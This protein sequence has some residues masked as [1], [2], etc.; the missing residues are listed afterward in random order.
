MEFTA[1]HAK[2][3]KIFYRSLRSVRPLRFSNCTGRGCALVGQVYDLTRVRLNWPGILAG[4]G[5]GLTYGLY[6]LFS[7]AAQRRYTSW[8]TLAYALGFGALFMLPLQSA[9]DLWRA[10]TDPA[11][12][13]WLVMMGL[14]PTLAS[15]VAFNAA[16]RR[17]PAS[18]AS[19]VATLEPVIAA[20][21]GW[22]FLGERLAAP[23]LLGAGL[24]LAAVV[25]LQREAL[26][27]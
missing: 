15:G 11:A 22:M 5:A 9:S 12:L 23:Q 25:I 17:I 1:K 26:K 19:I 20:L 3:A 16:L 27:V 7:K 18:S 24:I 2:G 13:F 6:T 21:L 4:L 10:V 8:A 14:V